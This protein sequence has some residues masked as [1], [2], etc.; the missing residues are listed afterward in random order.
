MEQSLFRSHF[1]RKER[2][3]GF[4]RESTSFFTE[5]NEPQ[6]AKALDSL[7]KEMENGSFSIVV[8][9]QFSSGKSTLLN[10]LMGE[11]YLPSFTTE[12]TA[13]INFLR[14]LKESP[15]GKPEVV[16]HYRDGHSEKSEDVS[17]GGI[18]RFV[19]INED[20][21]VKEKVESVEV[22]LDSKFLTDGVSLVDSPGLNGM[23]E[24]HREITME[25][26][27]RSH[28]AIFLFNAKQPGS[29]ADFEELNNLKNLCPSLF[30]VLNQIDLINESEQSVDDV[31][32][33]VLANYRKYFKTGKLPKIYPVSAY[34]ALV[35]RSKLNLDFEGKKNFSD[36]EKRVFVNDSLMEE[37]EDRLFRYLT[38]GEKTLQELKSPIQKALVFLNESVNDV[39]I[40][41]TDLEQSCDPERLEHDIQLLSIQIE[42]NKKQSNKEKSELSNSINRLFRK[43][44]ED[45]SIELDG[46]S[47]RFSQS[48]SGLEGDELVQAANSYFQR[49]DAVL[50]GFIES[51][52]RE[53]ED[54]YRRLILERFS[55]YCSNVSR[56]VGHNPFG[57]LID[58]GSV[59]AVS[60]D[61][62]EGSSSLL[63]TEK[64]LED[65]EDQLFECL[66]EYDENELELAKRKSNENKKEQLDREKQDETRNR[67]DLIRILGPKPGV[68]TRNEFR[69]RQIGGIK[70]WLAGIW[71][72]DTGR[73]KQVSVTVTDS[74]LRDDWEEE[75]KR[76]VEEHQRK[77]MR[78]DEERRSLDTDSSAYLVRE[79]QLMRKKERIEKQIEEVKNERE[80]HMQSDREARNT[81]VKGQIRQILTEIRRER[82][83]SFDAWRENAEK[84]AE[85]RAMDYLEKGE[86]GLTRNEIHK[87]ESRIQVLRNDAE[88][89]EEFLKLCKKTREEIKL[90]IDKGDSVLSDLEQI[91]P[92]QITRE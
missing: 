80:R 61:S 90:L 46:M 89:R 43:L 86:D 11:K 51:R 76:I 32:D 36:E 37:F 68:E 84:D 83:S 49:H 88:K 4:L 75:I 92:D 2:V 50:Q 5:Q 17:L 25:Q 10:A 58:K 20:L 54:E 56:I 70:G 67:D 23:A 22:F 8:V 40:K 31:V 38:Q 91:K 87:L 41:I 26:I 48:V 79:K 14:P 78:I 33:N 34:K 63:K 74:T 30:I 64:R 52:A 73:F 77:L 24:G 62:L 60:E 66:N 9:G 59:K 13:T 81:R 18:Q 69:E 42:E 82:L 35:G 29:L 45:I 19:A 27:N 21:N 7:T 55:D 1:E 3:L 12:T 71:S 57:F 44:R 47:D 85:S 65:L 28:A 15:D 6:K 53:L 72:G 16:I 39:S